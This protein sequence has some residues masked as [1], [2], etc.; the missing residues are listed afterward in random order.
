MNMIFK[1]CLLF[2]LTA[3]LFKK[4]FEIEIQF[5]DTECRICTKEDL[6]FVRTVQFS[7]QD[8]V[9]ECARRRQCKALN[10]LRRYPLCELL[11]STDNSIASARKGECVYV[12]KDDI[13][14]SGVPEICSQCTDL[15]ACDWDTPQC[16]IEECPR[17]MSD[18][19]VLQGN[20]NS[21]GNRIK[22]TCKQPEYEKM[23][24]DE[25]YSTCHNDGLW[26]KPPRCELNV[27][28]W[29]NVSMSSQHNNDSSP[30]NGVD[31]RTYQY[32]ITNASTSNSCFHTLGN[33]S[34]PWWGVDLGAVFNIFLVRIFNR[35]D[36][37]YAARARNVVLSLGNS[38]NSM[39]EVSYKGGQI[40]DVD[41]FILMPE[42]SAQF[43]KLSLNLT[44]EYTPNN[45]FNHPFHLCEVQVLGK[46]STSS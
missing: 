12:T 19:I 24:R 38:S 4:T 35:I 41:E 10:Y 34:Q 17:I 7:L 11:N 30:K 45:Q 2:Q 15:Q 43:V 32:W 13:H 31:G 5:K 18:G 29:K 25:M 26:E 22:Y 16:V 37:D 40:K 8:C 1:L 28:L 3:I 27:A 36:K 21:V 44:Q 20:M 39:M 23:L 9:K 46:K 14:V 6:Y 33:E 42:V